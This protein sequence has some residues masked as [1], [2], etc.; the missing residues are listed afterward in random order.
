MV[1]EPTEILSEAVAR[2]FGAVLSLPSAGM[3]RHCKTRFLMEEPGA[4]WIESVS[5]QTDLI[6][7]LIAQQHPV[8]I[9]F[10]SA[11][12]K[13]VF[14]TT[15]RRRDPGF[16]PNAGLTLEALLLDFPKDIK[17]VQRRSDYRVKIVPD[18][19]LET[20]MWRIPEHFILRD[21]P[22]GTFELTARVRD[23]ST[24]G[25]G[26]FCSSRDGAD[27]KLA[28]DQRLRIMLRFEDLEAVIE[29][30]ARHMVTTPEKS[31][32]IGVQFKKLENDLE[33][34]QILSKL[35]NI[36]A[37]LQRQEIRRAIISGT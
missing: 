8:G 36:V 25:M 13:V 4:F 16:S 33:G 27:L 2:N 15:V 32:R 35:T 20:R 5:G 19:G 10:K 12:N 22:S 7:Q 23:L 34:R 6:D 3:L 30:R 37:R 17:A 11:T 21:R 18:C 29:G 24:G 14:T 28:P 26:V 31:I 1:S 9:A